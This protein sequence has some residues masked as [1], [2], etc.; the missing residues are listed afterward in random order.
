MITEPEFVDELLDAITE[1]NMKIIDIALEYDIDGFHFG[2]DWG[3]QAGLIMGPNYWRR[4][5][6]PRM[7]RMY[8]RAKK[9]GEIYIPAFLRRHS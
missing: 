6:K 5:I 3:Q 9:Q 4:F 2:D 8:E 7:A 1:Y